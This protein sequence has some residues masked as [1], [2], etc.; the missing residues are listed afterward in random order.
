MLTRLEV[1]SDRHGGN[2]RSII[3]TLDY[4]IHNPKHAVRLPEINAAF[5]TPYCTKQFMG[6]LGDTHAQPAITEL[7]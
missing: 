5:L 3:Q 4:Q 6:R 7:N 1:S 2:H